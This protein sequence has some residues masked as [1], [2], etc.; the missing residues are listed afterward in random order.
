[1]ANLF[2]GKCGISAAAVPMQF[3]DNC[4]VLPAPLPIWDAPE[5]VVNPVPPPVVA[6]LIPDFTLCPTLAGA[7]HGNM[8]GPCDDNYIRVSAATDPETCALRVELDMQIPKPKCPRF[9]FEADVV[10]VTKPVPAC[11]QPVG[12]FN[13]GVTTAAPCD[14]PNCDYLLDLFFD[15]EL[16]GVACPEAE[17]GYASG[18]VAVGGACDP[19]N[20]DI[21]VNVI[22]KGD[23]CKG[24]CTG[25]YNFDLTAEY[26]APICPQIII[27]GVS[28]RKDEGE[29]AANGTMTGDNCDELCE[30]VL[31][32]DFAIPSATL[33]PSISVPCWPGPVGPAGGT[34]PDGNAGPDGSDGSDGRNGRDGQDGLDGSN[35][36]PGRNGPKGPQGPRGQSGAQGKTGPGLTGPDGPQGPPGTEPGPKGPTGDTGPKLAI[37]EVQHSSEAKYVG[38]HCTEMP[39]VLFAD[40]VCIHDV[41]RRGIGKIDPLF[42]QVCSPDS[43]KAVGAYTDKPAA[44]GAVIDGQDI[45]VLTD[46]DEQRTVFVR[47]MG[48]RR[49]KA[50]VRFPVFT[51]QQARRNAAFWAKAYKV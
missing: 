4:E 36:K 34:G 15:I 41:R 2:P 7:G 5:I 46:T 16:P 29:F 50:G 12:A 43:I 40:D 6:P 27:G 25:I 35:G 3:I 39:E 23:P 33:L 42:L 26:P 45:T 51:E 17:M 9:N 8:A 24:S 44:V 32:F 18:T 22:T 13:A 28:V 49:N 20:I 14:G 48:T 11:G 47:I 31:D 30:Y 10:L 19:G 38:L 21:A 1:M 37:V